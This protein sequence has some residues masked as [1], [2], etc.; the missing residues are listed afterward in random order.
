M[1]YWCWSFSERKLIWKAPCRCLARCSLLRIRRAQFVLPHVFVF[2]KCSRYSY[3]RE[4]FSAW[5][6]CITSLVFH[7]SLHR[8]GFG[9]VSSLTCLTDNHWLWLITKRV[10]YLI[11]ITGINNLMR[12]FSETKTVYQKSQLLTLFIFKTGPRFAKSAQYESECT[13]TTD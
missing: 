4:T 9:C 1:W 5:K 3:D 10:L 12:S 2:T 7:A 13:V 8:D 6:N 11:K